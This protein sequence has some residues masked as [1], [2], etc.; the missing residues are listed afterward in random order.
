MMNK[1][2]N[3][4]NKRD[5]D[6]SP[7]G[8]KPAQKRVYEKKAEVALEK[9]SNNVEFEHGFGNE[10]K[11]FA[12]LYATQHGTRINVFISGKKLARAVKKD[13]ILP[14]IRTSKRGPIELN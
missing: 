9:L 12:H 10:D 13:I 14:K 6:S 2:Q 11:E 7:E 8:K 4:N 5:A 3:L 1:E